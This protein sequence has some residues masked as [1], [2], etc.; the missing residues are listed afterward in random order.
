MINYKALLSFNYYPFH[1]F[2]KKAYIKEAEFFIKKIFFYL[3]V[4]SYEKK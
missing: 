2:I 1:F 4:S 3:I